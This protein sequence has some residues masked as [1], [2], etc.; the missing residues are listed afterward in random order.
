M[1]A[2]WR[3]TEV[4][5]HE[6]LSHMRAGYA[7]PDTGQVIGARHGIAIPALRLEGFKRA[8]ESD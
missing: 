8:A 4:V 2:S 1:S 6:P 5:A 3:A 7:A